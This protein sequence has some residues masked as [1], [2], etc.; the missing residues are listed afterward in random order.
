MKELLL[1]NLGLKISA[2]LIAIF[3]WLFVTSQ[4]QSEIF[5]EIPIEFKNIPVGLGIASDG[6]KTVQVTIRGQEL[7][8]K[9][10]RPSDARVYV[11]LGNAKAGKDTYYIDKDDIKLPYAAKVLNV[12]PS[13]LQIRLDE[14]I[15]K[16]V[17]IKPTISG[18]PEKGFSVNTIRVEPAT[19]SV[20]GLR[21]EIMK[22]RELRTEPMDIT[23]LRE[24]TSQSLNIDTR[25]ANIK[26]EFNKVKVT[27]IIVKQ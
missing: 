27:A 15:S 9:N 20:Q 2:I 16:I 13:S 11:D 12:Q 24:T 1:D 25:G 14:T 8:I 23:G 5:F 26:P 19:L 6:K 22:I 10:I 17:T 7:M 21:S 4:G 3:L 18:L